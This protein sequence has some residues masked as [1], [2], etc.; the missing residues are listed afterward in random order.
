MY[1]HIT[2]QKAS[3]ATITIEQSLWPRPSL[4]SKTNYWHSSWSHIS[5][6]CTL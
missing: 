3:C 4:Q 5:K 2:V 6:G 1:L